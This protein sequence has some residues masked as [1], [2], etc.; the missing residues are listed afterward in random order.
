M[1]AK[2]KTLL[3]IVKTWNI[4]EKPEY[5][6]FRCALC[7]KYIHKAYYYWL[8]SSEYL[9]PVHF[10]KDCRKKFETGKIQV[11]KPCLSVNRKTFGLDFEKNFIQ[12]C[13]NLIKKWNIKSKPIY[14]TFTCD[15]CGKNMHKA[16]HTWL[17]IDGRL[18]ELHFCKKC[19]NKLGLNKFK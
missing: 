7:Q 3:R 2:T 14:K 10:C 19:G 11:T 5:R 13:K 17:N 15:N 12:K 6:G 9:T 18:V 16:Y 8:D 1:D 4:K